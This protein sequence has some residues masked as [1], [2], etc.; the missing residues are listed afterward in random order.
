MKS[1]LIDHITPEAFQETYIRTDYSAYAMNQVSRILKHWIDDQAVSRREVEAITIDGATSLDLDDAIWVERTTDGYCLWVHISDVSEAIPIFSPLDIEAL[2]RTTSVYRKDHILD[3][4]PPELSNNTLSLDPYGW[5]KLTMTLQVDLDEQW[6]VKNHSYYESR[7]TNL[8]RYDYESF[9]EDFM[10]PE[11]EHHETLKLLK[12]VSD[13][14]RGRRIQDWWTLNWTDDGRRLNIWGDIERS[15]NIPATT[16]ISHDIIE[17]LMVLAN[18]TTWQHLV[19]T[20]VPTLL[21]RHDSL[22]ERSFY[23]HAPDSVHAWLGMTNYTHFT[24][25]IRRYVDLIIHRTI[26]ALERREEAPYTTEDVKFTAKHS[27]NTRWKV[28]TLWA[29]IDLDTRGQDF[30]KRTE[31]RLGRPL[32][33]YDLKP[34][35]RNST[36]K[37][38]K[39]P[40]VMKE[41]ITEL[42]Q[43]WD[44]SYWTWAV[45]IIILWK[46]EDLKNLMKKRIL[47]DWVLSNV[48]FLNILTQTQILRWEGTIFELDTH[49]ESWNISMKLSCKWVIIAKSK[50]TL[51]GSSD[52]RQLKHSCRTKLIEELF[53]YYIKENNA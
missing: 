25:P 13:K 36:H 7:F 5:K 39:L 17:S 38:L 52:I 2:H 23:H 45:W 10:N 41:S 6:N 47:E 40:K 15:S 1:R 18:V 37:S 22:D 32:E 43:S 11:S 20:G 14:L 49:E 12:E 16:R 8:K 42:M 28:E 24:S 3:M 27:N 46:D 19:D 51:K 44:T 29:Q 30:I 21:K 48:W 34:Y 4:F 31:K 9:G 50:W 53:D 35:I 33:V 26:K